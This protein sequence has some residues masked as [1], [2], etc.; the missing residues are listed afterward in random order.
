MKNTFVYKI[1]RKIYRKILKKTQNKKVEQYKPL[2]K[3]KFYNEIEKYDII[4]FDIFDTLLTRCLYEPDDLFKIMS[5]ILKIDDFLERRKKSENEAIKKYQHD[6]NLTEIYNCYKEIYKTNKKETDKIKNLEIELELKL[7]VP[8]IEMKEIFDRLIKNKKNVI[9]TSDMYLEK[10][11]IEKML[12]KCGYK[13]YK[14]FY[15][16]NELNARKDNKKIWDK[17]NYKNKKIIHIGDN[18]ISDYLYP[19]ELGIDTIKIESSKELLKKSNIYFEIKNLIEQRSPS[20]SIYLGLIF[21]KCIF[22]SPFS[23]LKIKDLKTFAYAF[24]SPVIAKFIRYISQNTKKNDILLFLSREG[25]YLKKLYEYYNQNKHN[26][27]L[28]YFLTSRKS[29]I[30]PSINDENDFE[31]ILNNEYNGNIKQYFE[32]NLEIDYKEEDFEIT[33]PND[34]E[35]VLESMKKY[36]KEILKNSA[37]Q[38]ENYLKYINETIPDIKNKSIT[39]IDLGYSG[40]I[41]YNLSKILN[42]N[43]KG[44]YLT[45]SS[46]VKKYKENQ[47]NFL[48]D[49]NEFDY[50]FI[51]HYSLLLEYFLTAPFGQLQKFE[52]KNKKITPIYNK[53][54]LDDDRKKTINEIYAKVTEYIDDILNIEEIYKVNISKKII[55][56]VYKTLIESN[57]IDKNVK[58]RFN[59]LDE[60]GREETKNIFK[61]ISRY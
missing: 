11:T 34:K 51:Y 3:E 56:T 5:E 45:N 7:I 50:S 14:N 33:L 43:L 22:N 38:R 46:N 47:L 53:E 24:H 31:S 55:Y 59:Y 44:L 41:Q 8:R 17:I 29:T 35:K 27:E 48:F 26:N 36:K 9:L 10:E 61:T 25:Y 54:T 28:I 58:D 40:T 6:V 21:N 60:F 1:L 52:L 30:L 42:K 12:E 39:L 19:K 37:I 49:I 4:S 32:K 23:D 13:N 20:D 16:S 15:L 18:G 2:D 57:V